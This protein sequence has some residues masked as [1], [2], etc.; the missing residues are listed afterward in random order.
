MDDGSIAGDQ[1]VLA[2]IFDVILQEGPKIGLHVNKGKC[3][4]WF[5]V[6]CPDPLPPLFASGIQVHP[7]EEGVKV[8]GCPIG[9]AV[10]TR[11]WVSDFLS[12]FKRSLERLGQ[13]ASPR[14]ASQILRNCLG[15]AKV[16][17]LLRT[18]P[19]E[20]GVW[21]ANSTSALIRTA[22]DTVMGCTLSETS[23]SLAC[24]PLDS[25]GLG[26]LDPAKA[27]P[28]A[29]VASFLS[30]AKSHHSLFIDSL[31]PGF[32]ESVERLSRWCPE[33][34]K[35]LRP[36]TALSEVL[37]HSELK[38]WCSQ[39]AWYSEQKAVL[40][41]SFSTSSDLRSRQLESLQ[42]SSYSSAWLLDTGKDSATLGVL[43][44]TEWQDL[45]K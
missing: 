45:L 42:S 5:P 22:W 11:A 31:P 27:Q 25:G 16:M 26:V 15:A 35:E 34:T 38:N 21:L 19:Y 30:A 6:P 9:S 41:K 12:T 28:I 4:L 3:H 14:A 1:H 36:L 17:F 32:V 23:W 24:L 33:M 39:A 13:L 10:W 29:F 7:P 37:A 20:D 43:S 2:A 40:L 8:L 44:S 18:L